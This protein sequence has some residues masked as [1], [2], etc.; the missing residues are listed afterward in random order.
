MAEMLQHYTADNIQ[1]LANNWTFINLTS[2]KNVMCIFIII[3][4]PQIL[5]CNLF[6]VNINFTQSILHLR[7]S[8]RS[9]ATKEIARISPIDSLGYIF[10]VDSM[11]L[12]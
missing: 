8:A 11:G 3:Q 9:S 5:N 2:F 7:C 10:V 1:Q 4:T 12:A 6:R